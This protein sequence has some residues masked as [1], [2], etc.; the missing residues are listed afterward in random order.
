VTV[1][2][3]TV[4]GGGSGS[5]GSVGVV[6]SGGSVIEVETTGILTVG[7][8]AGPGGVGPLAG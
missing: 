6:V 5:V 8:A 1:G 7:A 3:V 2:S 4:G